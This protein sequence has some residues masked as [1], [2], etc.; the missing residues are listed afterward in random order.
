MLEFK[1]LHMNF[2][3]IGISRNS[4]EVTKIHADD[5]PSIPPMLYRSYLGP[6]N[7]AREAM[8]K[9]RERKKN[10]VPCVECCRD[11]LN[12]VAVFPSLELDEY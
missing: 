10:V 7:N 8:R 9:A 5:C 4:S 1:I 3:Y 2:F 12:S 6:F 11:K